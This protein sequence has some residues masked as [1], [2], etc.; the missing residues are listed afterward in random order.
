MQNIN[1]EILTELKNQLGEKVV[2]LA[3]EKIEKFSISGKNPSLVLFPKNIEQVQLTMKLARKYKKKI[4]ILGNNT[5]HSLGSLPQQFDWALSMSQLKKIISFDA[6]DLTITVEPGITL[7]EIQQHIRS[8]NQFLPLDPICDE[9]ATV[10]GIVAAGRSGPWRLLYGACPDLVL[11]MKVVLPNGNVI[12]AGGKTVKNVAGYNLGRL[13]IAS[14]G[15]LGAICEI[16]FKLMP[17]MPDSQNLML[18]FDT[19]DEIANFTKQVLTSKLVISRCEYFNKIFSEFFLNSAWK[20]LA[21][22]NLVLNISGNSKMV[23]AAQ[24]RLLTLAEKNNKKYATTVPLS[25]AQKFWELNFI[26]SL[27]NMDQHFLDRAQI[28]VPKANLWSIIKIANN[29]S[30]ENN[31]NIPVEASAGNGLLN[32]FLG[33]KKFVSRQ[34][35]IQKQQI[36]YFREQA[37]LLGGNLILQQTPVELRL[38][39]IIW[40]KPDNSFSVMQGIKSE[41]DADKI[42]AHG[43]FWGGL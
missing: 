37:S 17:V 33:D 11:G 10:G 39:E 31:C 12:K 23:K 34:H 36:L 32:L 25:G 5:Q 22:H 42:I 28:S 24:E 14:M 41:Y 27:K 3:S 18:G 40:G 21:I 19:L 1:V 9:H 20:A 26:K 4:L 43:R 16:T 35:E 29:F 7:F 2:S 30:S 38:P 8:R 15:T 13:F 6:E